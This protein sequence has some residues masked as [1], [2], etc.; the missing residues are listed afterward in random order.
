MIQIITYDTEKYKDY[1]DNAYTISRFDE[2]Q[3]FDDFEICVIDLTNEDIW[4]YDKSKPININN[5][6]DLLT[7]KEAIQNCSA[8]KIII[9]FPQNVEFAYNK[10]YGHS[11]TKYSELIQL[12]DN[13]ENLINIIN[14]NLY[15]VDCFELSFEKTKTLIGDKKINADFNFKVFDDKYRIITCSQISKKVTTIRRD[16]IYLTT[17]Y[18]VE[19]ESLLKSFIYLYCKDNEEK[20][21]IPTWAKSIKFYNDDKLEKKQCSND[22]K[23]QELKDENMKLQAQLNENMRY[24]SILYSTGEELVSVVVEILDDILGYDSSKFIDEKKEDFLI[25][26]ED[27]T[28]IGEIKGLSSAVKNENL[29][30]LEVHV[31]NYFDKLQEEN[32][33]ENIKGL[34]VI[35]HQRNKPLEERQEIHE[36]Q[37]KLA[38]KYGSLVVETKTLLKLYEKYKN[39]DITKEECKN[40]FMSEVGI[41]K[42]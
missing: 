6:N 9:I 2:I 30:Q 3:A 17:L 14:D 27:V 42:L 1:P 40:L 37:K 29:S 21:D 41:L 36:Y 38:E 15:Q 39:K 28:F 33:E 34:L 11:G 31:Q 8:P 5:S 16:S 13:K 20:A 22:E 19:N 12:K 35:N 24:K 10:I 23:I 25:K 4:I 26:K 18:L 7:M 32:K